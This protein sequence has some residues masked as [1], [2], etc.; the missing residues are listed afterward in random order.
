VLSAPD[1]AIA[2][3]LRERFAREALVLA[4]IRSRYVGQILGFGFENHQ[5]FLVLERLSGET[6]DALVKRRTQLTFEEIVPYVGHVLLALRDCHANNVVHRDLKPA[7][8]YLQKLPTGDTIAK[9]IDF[10][11]A[12]SVQT[13]NPTGLTSTQHLLGSV[14]YMAPEQFHEAKAAGPLSDIYATGTVIFRCLT[15]RLPFVA[16]S[17]EAVMQLKSTMPLPAISQFD[18]APALPALDAFCRKAAAL[19][20]RD[21]FQSAREMLHAWQDVVARSGYGA[22]AAAPAEPEWESRTQ[23]SLSPQA[24]RAL[25]NRARIPVELQAPLSAGVRPTTLPLSAIVPVEFIELDEDPELVPNTFAQAPSTRPHGSTDSQPPASVAFAPAPAIRMPPPPVRRPAPLAPTMQGTQ[26]DEIARADAPIDVSVAADAYGYSTSPNTDT[27]SIEA[28]WSEVD[29][30]D[31]AYDPPT[32][33]NMQLQDILRNE[34]EISKR[35]RG[36]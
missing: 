20:L 11:V 2:H 9:L 16:K 30:H 23:S 18:G 31:D 26:W 24:E 14:G 29:V 6:L 27:D 36:R 21:R 15:G 12:R 28:V 22:P 10:G 4:G 35:N 3:E 32:T 33:P 19:E 17:F 1:A 5:P 13:H 25:S 8:I 34:R 7:N